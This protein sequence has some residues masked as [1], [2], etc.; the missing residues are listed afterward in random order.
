MRSVRNLRSLRAQVLTFRSPTEGKP[1]LLCVLRVFLRL[2]APPRQNPRPQDHSIPTHFANIFLF[3]RYPST[4]YP[5]P[6]KIPYH[7]RAKS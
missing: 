4:T 1:S 7:P 2:S 3:F 5:H 6:L